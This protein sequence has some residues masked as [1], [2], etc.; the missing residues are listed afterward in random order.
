M[1]W[2]FLAK[3]ASRAMKSLLDFKFLVVGG[4]LKQSGNFLSRASASGI[5]S[6]IMKLLFSKSAP[7]CQP[8]AMIFGVHTRA[9]GSSRTG[10]TSQEAQLIRRRCASQFVSWTRIDGLS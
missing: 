9:T 8:Y 10:S 4:A 2:N 1:L 5:F 6:V 7:H 3:D